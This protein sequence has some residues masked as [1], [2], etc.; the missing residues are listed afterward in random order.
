M[1]KPKY[2]WDKHLA[3]AR[4]VVET[5]AAAL[6][7]LHDAIGPSFVQ[8]MEKILAGS[9][10]VIVTG[11]GKS[12][13]VA[14][15]A[16]ATLSSVGTPAK[17]L[18]P[19]EALHGDLGMVQEGDVLLAFS[20]SGAT[21]EIV[22]FV[23]HFK[24]IGGAV[25]AVCE[26]GASPLAELADVVI[27]LP[28]QPEAG[29]MPLAPTT[30]TTMMLAVGDAL[31]M[32]LLEARGFRSEQFA[33]Y[34]PEGSLGK[35]LLL[36]AADIMHGGEQLPRVSAD[37]TFNDLIIETTRKHVGMSCIVEPS[38]TL[39]GV[40][41][42]G[43]LRRL[44]SREAQPTRLTAREAWRLSRRDPNDTPVPHSTVPPEALAVDCLQMM[45]E[46]QIT[47]LVVAREDRIPLGIVRLQD[48]VK[49]GLG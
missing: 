48:L 2:D 30:S 42:D 39:L 43:D 23:G 20:K 6:R 5:E 45:R 21:E 35:R 34:H 10:Q 44:L 7:A 16:A 31:A 49:A 24:R 29:P 25:I 37:A 36:R 38:G 27:G 8:A 47:S 15:K 4:E 26:I 11:L 22:R 40:F 41:T 18:H 17:F 32:A 28:R 14:A 33:R 46:A 3:T 9:G 13:H 12:G 19:V 1:A